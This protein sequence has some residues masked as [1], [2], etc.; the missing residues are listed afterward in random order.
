MNQNTHETYLRKQAVAV[1][2][3]WG[4]GFAEDLLAAAD[5]IQAAEIQITLLY[6]LVAAWSMGQSDMLKRLTREERDGIME[7]SVDLAIF[8]GRYSEPGKGP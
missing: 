7:A 4:E 1:E 6:R 3:V 2:N 8:T 5:E